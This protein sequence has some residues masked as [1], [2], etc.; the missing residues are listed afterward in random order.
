MREALNECDKSHVYGEWIDRII[1]LQPS[2]EAL[3]A[4]VAKQSA[5]LKVALGALCDF[6]YDRRMDAIRQINELGVE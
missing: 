5:V 3:D 2:T 4:Y 1:A 6:D